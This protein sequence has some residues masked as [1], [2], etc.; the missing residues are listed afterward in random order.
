[1]VPTVGQIPRTS[2]EGRLHYG[3]RTMPVHNTVDLFSVATFL[4]AVTSTV[5]HN[6]T[7]CDHTLLVRSYV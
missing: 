4:H 3:Q 1:M 2:A 5:L 7:A 6:L